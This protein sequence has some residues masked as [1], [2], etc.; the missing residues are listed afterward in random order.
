MS[1]GHDVVTCT[2]VTRSHLGF[3]RALVRTLRRWHPDAR[4]YVLVVDGSSGYFDPRLED[5]TVVA[6]EELGIPDARAFCFQYT[7][8]ELCNALKAHLLR[9]VLTVRGEPAALY[10]DGD[11]GVYGR[12]DSLWEQVLAH[13][14]VLVPH[15]GETP[16]RDGRFPGIHDLLVAGTYNAGVLG[17]RTSDD[18]RKFL[19][20]WA[21]CVQHDCVDDRMEGVF[22]DQRFLDFVPALFPGTGLVRNIGVNVA[23]FNLHCRHVHREGDQWRVDGVP[24]LLFHFTQVRFVDGTFDRRITRAFGAQMDSIRALAAE[25][26]ADLEASGW[27]ETLEWPYGFAAFDSGLAISQ[28]TRDEFRKRWRSGAAPGDPFSAP[29]WEAFERATLRRALPKRAA[30]WAKKAWRRIASR[31]QPNARR[32]AMSR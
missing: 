20:W 12:L 4:A 18:G 15:S 26:L 5:F 17:V 23:H 13:D 10:L 16:P 29:E 27:S 6:M 28:S 24:L 14:V 31:L 8:F 9:H 2:V 25:F 32:G 7:P 3:V 30:G 1:K 19:E 22:V 21:R 11:I